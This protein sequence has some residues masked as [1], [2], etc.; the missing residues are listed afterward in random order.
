MIELSRR[1]VPPTLEGRIDA[2][3][4]LQ[5]RVLEK[6]EWLVDEIQ[7]A[8]RKCRTDALVSE[9]FSVLDHVHYLVTHARR[10]LAVHPV[11]TPLALFG[12]KSKYWLEPYGVVLVISPW[13]YPLNLALVP[14]TTALV[15]GNAV[16]FKPSEWTPMRGVLESLFEGLFPEGGFQVAYGD[17]ETAK[18]LIAQRPDKIFF[19]GSTATGKRILA[20]AA[21]LLVPVD[22]ELGG[23]DAMIVFDDV[24][25]E[26]AVQGALWGALTNSGQSCTSVERLL[27]QETIYEK[28]RDRLVEAAA[29][30]RVGVDTDG[31]TELGEM[32]APFQIEKVR[33]Q[34]DDAKA[35][36]ARVLTGLSWDGRSAAI[37]PLVVENVTD[38]MAVWNEET[39]GPVIAVRPFR[40]E[41]EAVRRANQGAYGLSAS[42]WSRDLKRAERVASALVVGNVSL[43]NVMLTEGNAALPFGGRKQSGFGRY[44]GDLGFLAFSA[45]KSVLVDKDSRKIESNW[46]PYSPRKY[47]LFARL[48]DA[49]FKRRWLTFVLTGLK[50]EKGEKH[51][52]VR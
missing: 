36:G 31:S 32:T 42:V 24:D 7:K 25:I 29:G 17:G 49:L 47:G 37:P 12:K 2:L 41:A 34:I 22:L 52:G 14:I 30:L 50:L 48:I 3:R 27:V 26:R 10:V 23:K 4:V 38:A 35:Q 33:L 46:F 43:N 8:T 18:G 19:T 9:I 13:N 51:A 28:F 16:V 45:V 5:S 11:P 15:C 39:F 21:E 40:D 44:K 20:Q 1:Y 6:R